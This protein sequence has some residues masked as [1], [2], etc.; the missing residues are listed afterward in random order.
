MQTKMLFTLFLLI[1]WLSTVQPETTPAKKIIQHE[2]EDEYDRDIHSVL[3]EMTAMLAKQN[4]QIMYLQKEN[5][6]QAAKLR[7]VDNLK[8]AIQA[9]TAKQKTTEEKLAELDKLKPQLQVKQVAFSASLVAT[10]QRHFGPFSALY[11]LAF[12]HVI[13]NIGNAYNPN[14]GVFTAPVKGAYHF[15][16]YIY[17]YGD[18]S[19]GSG[20]ILFK[21]G[22]HIFIAYEHQPSH[23]SSSSNGVTL[24]LEVGDVVYVRQRATA[25]IFDS[26][27][28]HTT[29][30]GHLL[31][32]M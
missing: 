11:T 2:K 20:A 9:Q 13:T 12:K 30:S 24:I 21:N 10:G 28:C 7:D 5:E 1:C 8:E 4:V 17:G 22:R 18:A 29:F 14:T 31:F 25:K 3:R 15:E 23:T 6:A 16:F 26:V 32:T 19:H 27:N